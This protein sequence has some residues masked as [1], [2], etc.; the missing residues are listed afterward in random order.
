MVPSLPMTS[1]S[2]VPVCTSSNPGAVAAVGGTS[3]LAT[4]EDDCDSSHRSCGVTA[5]FKSFAMV[6]VPVNESIL[7]LLLHLHKQFSARPQEPYRFSPSEARAS[8]ESRV[9]N[10]EFFI[11]KVLDKICLESG[12]C[13][14]IMNS[15]CQGQKTAEGEPA[16]EQSP[17][18]DQLEERFDNVFTVRDLLEERYGLL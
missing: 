12:K 2:A 6:D 15:L 7:S 16:T 4:T 13:L 5:D 11:K 10:A 14:E 3:V 8:M 17:V 1:M 18:R 9:G